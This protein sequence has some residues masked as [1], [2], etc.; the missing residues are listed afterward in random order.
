MYVPEA[1]KT[2]L[3]VEIQKHRKI[4]FS[5]VF[6]YI[7]NM[8]N[9]EQ[10]PWEMV[11]ITQHRL[12][13]TA[14]RVALRQKKTINMKPKSLT[15]YIRRL[16]AEMT[17]YGKTEGESKKDWP[18]PE[19]PTAWEESIGDDYIVCMICG[20]KGQLLTEPHLRHHGGSKAEYRRHF[21]I[22]RDVQLA[23]RSFLECRR[24]SILKNKIWEAKLPKV[25]RIGEKPLT[26]DENLSFLLGFQENKSDP[27]T[28]ITKEIPSDH[29]FFYE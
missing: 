17:G 23:A 26:P 1:R 11:D 28:E 2:V 16:I 3:R 27:I 15:K 9:T 12:Y 19:S 4:D 8:E 20:M 7:E 24:K 13:K 29:D 10:N 21:H 6:V 14:M 18:I 22:P 25:S 5:C